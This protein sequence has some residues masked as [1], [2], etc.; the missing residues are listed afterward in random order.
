VLGRCALQGNDADTARQQLDDA[1]TA[2]TEGGS[3]EHWRT[4]LARA[5]LGLAE[6]ASGQTAKARSNL[7]IAI[8]A[9]TATR[10]WLPDLAAFR[11]ARARLH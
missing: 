8:G 10:P 7:D 2:L 11:A 6:A 5:Q 3:A 4:M 9:L 1:V